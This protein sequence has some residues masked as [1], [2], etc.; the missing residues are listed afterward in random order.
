MALAGQAQAQE[1]VA[2]GMD[3]R[4]FRPAID[5]RGF[6]SLN[7]SEVMPK[8]RFS[9]GL[10]LDGGFN[11][12]PFDG[13]ID[14][15]NVP[16]A[17]AE[18]QDHIVDRMFT[19]TLQFNYAVLQDLVVGMQLPIQLVS[20]PRVEVPGVY[21]VGSP[22]GQSYQGIGDITLHAKYRILRAD[23]DPVGLAAIMH[24]QFPSGDDRA[25]A[26]E[27]GVALWPVLA[28]EY[29]PVSRLRL[30]LNLGYRFNAGDGVVFPVSG[31][32]VPGDPAAI[33]ATFSDAGTSLEY[34]DLLTFGA[35]VSVRAT[36]TLDVVAEVYGSQLVSE[37]GT[38]G[39]V[40]V[41]A[42]GGL[43][44]FV[45]RNSYLLLAG[46]VGFPQASFQAADYRGV[47]GFIFEP[48]LNDR[49]GDG[50]PDDIDQC[51]DD[52]EDLDDFEDE[53][54]CPDLDND[55]DGILDKDDRCPN[56]PEDF[57]GD[58]DED[59]CPDGTDGDRDGDGIPDAEDQCPDNPEDKDGF[60]DEDGCPDPDNDQDG[61]PDKEDL[62]PNDAEDKDGFEDKD[63]CPD[64]DNDKDRIADS[65]D[66]CPNKPETYNGTEDEDGCPD[67]GSVVIEDNQLLI[68]EKIY[69]ETDSSRI[70]QRSNPILNAVAAT[71]N[72]NPHIELIEVQGH[73]DERGKDSY[74]LRLTKSR[75]ASVVQALTDRGV[76]PSR[77][78][79][80][81][82]GEVC[83]VD[84][85]HNKAAWEKNR[86]VEF[87]IIR[88]ETGPTGVEV[89][90]PAG[91]RY[92]P[93]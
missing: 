49:D 62:C 82:Y 26:G 63:G 93:K 76:D 72:G 1:L 45:Q 50:I 6:I 11:I 84:P 47:L 23:K 38:S 89:A 20:G 43:K 8:G 88:T 73:A 22:S 48:S 36:D 55:K 66:R 3:L 28:A 4:L 54:G 79:S 57:D 17:D 21:N 69:F 18:R 44:V 53:D 60:E 15:E 91:R 87:K 74:N 29:R 27:P 46:G 71:L 2:G 80:A 90:C 37:F 81:G 59:G 7:G 64:P 42:I 58:R 30:G 24:F 13:Y 9:F 78:R 68:L 25:F 92:I 41:E 67:K 61:I 31:A 85:A 5:S 32:T 51:P 77:L 34:G 70:Q 86:R 52:P 65:D 40:S 10:I 35:G 16:A 12:L 56:I 83:P 75:A 19:G 14:D 39:A 33:N